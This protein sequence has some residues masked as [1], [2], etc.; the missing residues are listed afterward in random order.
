[1]PSRHPLQP[2]EG[3]RAKAR[4]SGEP[5]METE[6]QGAWQ[7]RRQ[8]LLSVPIK[9]SGP[10]SHR[11]AEASQGPRVHR[12]HRRQRWAGALPTD[13][14]SLAA[15]WLAQRVWA[16]WTEDVPHGTMAQGPSPGEPRSQGCTCSPAPTSAEWT[17]L[18]LQSTPMGRWRAPQGGPGDQALL[19]GAGTGVWRP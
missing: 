2:P 15:P 14:G 5:G 6:G 4:C 3:A 16:R 18:G 13:P 7:S 9:V 8:W 19:R 11:C 10:S 1:M 12:T 17:G